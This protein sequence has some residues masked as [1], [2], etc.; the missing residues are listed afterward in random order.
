MLRIVYFHY[1]LCVEKP[2]RPP[3]SNKLDKSIKMSRLEDC[4]MKKIKLDEDAAQMIASKAECV[5]VQEDDTIK[6][7]E[8]PGG[9]DDMSDS[10]D[11]GG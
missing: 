1:W 8:E 9:A 4:P 11:G 5:V 7:E 6:V 10:D 2:S 3:P